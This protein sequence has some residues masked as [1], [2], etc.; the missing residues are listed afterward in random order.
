MS[1]FVDAMGDEG[2]CEGSLEASGKI[3]C[4]LWMAGRGMVW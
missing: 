1:V 4:E 3:K 2:D